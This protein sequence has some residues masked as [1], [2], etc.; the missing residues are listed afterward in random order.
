MATQKELVQYLK[1]QSAPSASTID[2]LKIAYR[3]LICPFD[4]LLEILPENSS[5]FDIGCGSGMFL[6]LVKKF[7]APKKLGGIEISKQ[8]IENAKFVLGEENEQS[9]YLDTFNGKVIPVEIKSYDYVFMIDVFHHI[10][11]NAQLDF[12]TQLFEKMKAGAILVFKDIEG[13]SIFKYWNKVHDLLLAGEIGN[14]I[15]SRK[16]KSFLEGI[17][18]IE[19][20]NFNKRQ[21]FLYPHYTYLIKKVS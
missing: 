11:K 13:G 18:Q 12:L 5:V 20:I 6:A 21:M 2:K 16:L 1:E 14:E 9:V 8:L 3:P 7:K 17:K 15:S 10:P 19:I 4:D